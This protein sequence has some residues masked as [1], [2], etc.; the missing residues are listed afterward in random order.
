MNLSHHELLCLRKFSISLDHLLSWQCWTVLECKVEICL[1][2]ET[3]EGLSKILHRTS[4]IPIVSFQHCILLTVL[5]TPKLIITS[6]LNCHRVPP[7]LY[8]ALKF[9]VLWSGYSQNIYSFTPQIGTSWDKLP[10]NETISWVMRK[11]L[12]CDWVIFTDK[13][14]PQAS[15]AIEKLPFLYRLQ[16]WREKP[17]T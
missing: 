16:S 6:L 14:L 11:N 13:N 10:S 8:Y 9:S 2:Y 15:Y 12:G 1:L 17:M 7:E 4:Q 3:F 5:Y